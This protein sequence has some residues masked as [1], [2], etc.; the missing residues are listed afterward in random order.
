M[1]GLLALPATLTVNCVASYFVCD[2]GWCPDG[3]R[4]TF[5]ASDLVA[6]LIS[7]IAVLSSLRLLNKQASKRTGQNALLIGVSSAALVL[8]ILVI[9]RLPFVYT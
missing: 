9:V 5:F 7:C 2:H 8:A 4:W 3:P 1:I 6:W